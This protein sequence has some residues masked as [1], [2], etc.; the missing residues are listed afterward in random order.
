MNAKKADIEVLNTIKYDPKAMEHSAEVAALAD[1]VKSAGSSKDIGIV[2]ISFHQDGV[3]ILSRAASYPELM[4]LTWIGSDGTAMSPKIVSEAGEIAAKVKLYST[5]FAP[6]D[7]PKKEELVN[8]FKER[9]GQEPDSYTLVAYD[10]AWVAALTILQTGSLDGAV[11]A[12]ALPQVAD[13][14]FG[15]SGWTKLNEA[16]DRAFGDYT[17]YYVAQ[18]GG[19]YVWKVAGS[20]RS[21][22]DKI[23]WVATP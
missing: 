16:G 17:I 4:S 6:S 7:S 14:Y 22:A 19:K 21:L 13:K 12:R 10:C 20:Y 2:M 18:E 5:M 15:V 3:D 8:R 1:A 11:I 9:F 23:E